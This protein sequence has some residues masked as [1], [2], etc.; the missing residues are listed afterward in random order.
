MKDFRRWLDSQGRTP[1]DRTRKRKLMAL[2]KGTAREGRFK[3][4]S[5][6]GVPHGLARGP[7]GT[8]R[9]DEQ[10]KLRLPASRPHHEPA[11][12]CRSSPTLLESKQPRRRPLSS[13]CIVDRKSRQIPP[14][15]IIHC[16]SNGMRT[17]R[18]FDYACFAAARFAA[19]IL[20]VAAMIAARPAA[21][22]FR[23]SFGACAGADAVSFVAADFALANLAALAFFRFAAS[24][25]LAAA[26]SFR[27]GFGAGAGACGA[28]SLLILAHRSF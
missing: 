6:Y 12:I 22:S 10:K 23:F 17:F 2:A 9:F 20:F 13:A 8:R 27:L 26:D 11:G 28:A 15:T 16:C 5:D 18:R 24:V 7:E 1:A 25:A 4:P 21:L 19:H 14:G 3:C